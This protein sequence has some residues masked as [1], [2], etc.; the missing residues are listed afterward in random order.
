MFEKPSQLL[1]KVFET[2]LHVILLCILAMPRTFLL[3]Q[4]QGYRAA[5]IAL[6]ILLVRSIFVFLLIYERSGYLR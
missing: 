2:D 5:R 4:D 6:G 1:L 3:D